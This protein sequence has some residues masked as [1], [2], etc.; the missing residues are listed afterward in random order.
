MLALLFN[1]HPLSCLLFGDFS[2]VPMH[3]RLPAVSPTAVFGLFRRHH[4]FLSIGLDVHLHP[5]HT[6]RSL[7]TCGPWS[8]VPI[9][10]P[11]IVL[12]SVLRVHCI[13]FCDLS[14][15]VVFDSVPLL[16]QA[17]T[18]FEFA[19]TCSLLHVPNTR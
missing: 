14:H 7:H 3:C 18:R 4:A 6:I 13:Q 15:H 12:T 11:R 19:S 9:R 8:F 16:L 1:L 10:L 2:P 5:L 17:C